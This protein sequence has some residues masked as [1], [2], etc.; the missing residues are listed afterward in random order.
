ME[1]NK[2]PIFLSHLRLF[3]ISGLLLTGQNTPAQDISKVNQAQVYDINAEAR[4]DYSIISNDPETII[5]MKVITDNPTDFMDDYTIGYQVKERYNNIQP[6][7]TTL[8]ST[9]LI[10]SG[11]PLIFNITLPATSEEMLCAIKITN[12]GTK[13]DFYYDIPIRNKASFNYPGFY[14]KNAADDLPVF[15]HY[16]STDASLKFASQQNTQKIFGFRY[17]ADFDAAL[18]PMAQK[19]PAGNKLMT[20]D[21]VFQIDVDKAF[22]L[23]QEGLY[24][25]QED[26]TKL[27]GLAYRV[28]NRYFPRFVRIEDLSDPIVYLSTRLEF[29]SLNNS[30]EKKKAMDSFWIKIAGTREKAKRIIRNYYRSVEL[31]NKMFTNYKAGW[32]TDQGMIYII[33]GPPE[34]VY[35][36]EFE[37]IWIYDRKENMSKIKFT[38]TKVKSI[39]TKKHYELNRD[40]SYEKYWYRIIDLWRKGRKGI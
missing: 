22:T 37:E 18:P 27:E 40:K 34:E 33:Y 26:T 4:I 15:N 1:K 11:G 17:T 13:R 12:T 38:F 9:D 21:S 24:F 6:S 5:Y 19:A 30:E 23:S 28:S 29:K 36:N 25:F 16:L 7:F 31:A 35:R 10:N 14:L 3:L 39:F 8:S 2:L 32:K 20:I